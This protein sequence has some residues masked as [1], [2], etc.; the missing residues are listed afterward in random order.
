MAGWE[1]SVTEE[2]DGE[3]VPAIRPP[4]FYDELGEEEWE[5]LDAGPKA[6]LEF[7]N[8]LAYLEDHLPQTGHVLDIGG[9]AGRY[10]VWLAE[11]G[12]TVTLADVSR[13]QLEIAREKLTDRGL[14]EYVHVHAGD[15]RALPYPTATF[16]AVC[17][18]GGP[19]SH[20]VDPEDRDRAAAELRRA[21]RST[22]PVFVSVMGFI[23]VLQR[24]VQA[25]PEFEQ[26][27]TQ[28]PLLLE[29]QTYDASLLD[30]AGVEDPTFVACHFFR[31]AELRTLLED[32]GLV[33][34][35]LV[36]LE[37]I[38]SNF[39]SALEGA[40]PGAVSMIEQVVRDQAVREDPT[41]AD[42]SNH[43]LAVAYPADR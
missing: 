7:E 8:T 25:A 22:A 23:A 34:E 18:L 12:Y 11:R 30:R 19:L 4:R 36:G 42:I 38:A 20:V 31:A 43:I 14:D 13:G 24:L 35:A 27:V 40:S 28:L 29:T 10:A 9:A 2:S 15:L 5:R 33:V 1:V 41:V 6:R 3:H 21:A 16:D 26:G 32:H 37:G 39:E 17:C